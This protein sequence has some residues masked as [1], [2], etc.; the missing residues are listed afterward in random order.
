MCGFRVGA[1]GGQANDSSF[2]AFPSRYLIP[3]RLFGSVS[4]EVIRLRVRIAACVRVPI[5]GGLK[6]EVPKRSTIVVFR[7]SL[8][9]VARCRDSSV[10]CAAKIKTRTHCR[11]EY[12][13]PV[14]FIFRSTAVSPVAS[15][16]ERYHESRAGRT[17]AL[18]RRKPEGYHAVELWALFF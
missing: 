17:P 2:S 16:A 11:A 3:L 12:V 14:V 4:K 5:L 10:T 9:F 18:K 1:S 15:V 8:R 6:N 13:F 7:A